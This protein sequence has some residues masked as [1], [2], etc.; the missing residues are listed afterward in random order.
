MSRIKLAHEISRVFEDEV[1]DLKKRS[2]LKKVIATWSELVFDHENEHNDVYKGKCPFCHADV[3]DFLVNNFKG[4][5]YCYSC[6]TGGDAITFIAKK[7]EISF[8]DACMHLERLFPYT[9]C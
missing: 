5:F 8:F 6:H 4:V 7:H 2:N 9:G 1:N 3:T